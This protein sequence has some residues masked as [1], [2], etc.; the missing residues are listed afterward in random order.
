MGIPVEL[1][2]TYLAAASDASQV[3]RAYIMPA[4]TTLAVLASL[5]CVFF[6]VTGG[7]QYMSSTG[8]PDKL[9]QAKKVI[10]NALIGLV[11]VIAAGTLTAILSNAY[12]STGTAGTEQFPALQ[13]IKPTDDGFNLFDVV[14]NT[15]VSVLRNIVQSIGEPF[16]SA[17]GYFTNSTPLMANNAS[18]FN[19][20]LA[21][22]GITDVLF[23]LVVALIGFQIM[24]AATLGFDEIELKQLLPQ[25]AF[26]FLLIN[27]SIFVLDAIIGLSNAMIYALQSGFQSTSVWDVLADI[28]KQS[29]E[30]GLA[31]L[32]VMI[33]FLVLSV[34]LLVYYVLRLVGLYLG[35]ILAPIVVLLWLLPAFKDF[36]ITAL[37]TYLVAVFVLF[38][39]VVILLLAASIFVGIH[40]G[41]P[42]AQPNTLMALIV[43]L[44]TVIAL[45]K[46]QG[47]MNQL[48]SAA[49]APKA[50]RELGSSFMRGVSYMTRTART[51]KNFTQ[52]TYK[53]GM[54]VNKYIQ[55]KQAAKAEGLRVVTRPS[56]GKLTPTTNPLKTGETRKAE[57][58]EKK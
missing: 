18:V 19:L 41:D 23:I 7:I 8:N 9:E 44:A 57:K 45:L 40:S 42:G 53:T 56:T 52:G 31:G 46:A 14:I 33:A 37:K 47:M 34:M 48:V 50:A 49:S 26:I 16:V 55:K 29:S 6:L 43:G 3:M 35:A 30:M 10:R 51:T 12:S 15:I 20:W 13:E 32:L 38:V 36:A 28:T 22:V 4:V 21:V 25:M 11:L 27:T 5:A 39:H 54:K 1:P 2:L 58:A 24:S 17:L